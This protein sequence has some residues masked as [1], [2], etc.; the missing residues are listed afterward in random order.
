MREER[1]TGT[2][3]WLKA[4]TWDRCSVRSAAM[5]IAAAPMRGVT[6]VM[7]LISLH[8]IEPD[9]SMAS[10]CRLPVG[11]TIPVGTGLRLICGRYPAGR[12]KMRSP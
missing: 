5:A 7:P 10:R 4:M 2:S 3:R 12:L 8:P 6:P 1:S 11:F 9:T